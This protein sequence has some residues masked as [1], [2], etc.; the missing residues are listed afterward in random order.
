MSKKTFIISILLAV[1]ISFAIVG[2]YNTY[3]VY[4]KYD[5]TETFVLQN[6]TET[7]SLEVGEE[8]TIVY[9]I[10]NNNNGT[11][12][13]AVGYHSSSNY[14]V[15]VNI[16]SYDPVSGIIHK[17]ENKFV[18]LHIKNT[19]SSSVNCTIETILGYEHGGNLV[20][21]QDI[22]LVTEKYYYGIAGEISESFTTTGT[23]INN[24]ITYAIDATHS[25]IKDTMGNVRYYGASPNNYI[26]FNCETYPDT[27]CETW[28]I[29]GVVDDKLKIM[30]NESIGRLS[31]STTSSEINDGYGIN[32]WSQSPLMK[33]LNPGYEDNQ[34]LDNSGNNVTVSN[35]LYYNSEAGACYT[36]RYNKTTQLDFSSTG[37]KNDE[38]RNKIAQSVFYTAGAESDSSNNLNIYADQMLASERGTLVGDN[39]GDGI[40][41][42]TSW[43]SKIAVPY[44]SDYAYAADL[45]LCN[46]YIIQY[47][48]ANCMSNNWMATIMTNVAMHIWLISPNVNTG[49]G[50][51]NYTVRGTGTVVGSVYSNYY[52][53]NNY[54]TFPTLYLSESEEICGGTGESGSPWQLCA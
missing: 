4:T 36:A 9:Q 47:N 22:T 29:I 43:E 42:K 26:Y 17:G 19:S 49:K 38:T 46:K 1:A 20:V 23:V 44:P 11:V 7:V 32:E 27:N 34:G 45:S 24:G 18:K 37:I 40:E 12:Q 15:K 50:M 13:Y 53:S 51:R 33:V 10:K 30:R 48:D 14:V 25:L 6:N 41:R 8:K 35:S 31:F 54:Q 16:D 52:A 2:L 5:N 39:S 28:R 3:A 21:P